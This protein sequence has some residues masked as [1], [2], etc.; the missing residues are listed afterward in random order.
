M[1]ESPTKSVPGDLAGQWRQR[2]AFLSDFGDANS[3]RLW[4]TAAAELDDALKVH[5]E[6]TLTLVEAAV[7]SGYTADHLGSLVRSGKIPNAGRSDAPRIRHADLPN[8]SP[9]SP[10]RPRKRKRKG[11]GIISIK[12]KLSTSTRR[13]T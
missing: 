13:Q 1:Q 6:E 7:V 12:R 10:G 9:T 4:Q 11:A 5:A 8:K 2:A 3:A